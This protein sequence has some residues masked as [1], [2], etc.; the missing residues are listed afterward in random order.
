MLKQASYL[1]GWSIKKEERIRVFY[2][3]AKK[4][5]LAFIIY[6]TIPI[7]ICC[8]YH[9]VYCHFKK[10]EKIIIRILVT[11]SFKVEILF[12]PNKF[13][14]ISFSRP[15]LWMVLV[16]SE[17][18]VWLFTRRKIHGNFDTELWKGY[19]ISFKTLVAGFLNIF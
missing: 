14:Y 11:E 2:W 18:T 15:I 4:I 19:F 3:N 17:K 10:I 13:F 9:F 5:L 8:F 6:F 7:Q 1:H 12:P 16:E